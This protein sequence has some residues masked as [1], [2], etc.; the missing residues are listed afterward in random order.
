[1]DNPQQTLETE[2]KQQKAP[3]KRKWIIKIS[4][5]IAGIVGGYLY[6]YFV[7]CSTGT[8]PLKSNPWLMMLWGGLFAYL[9][10][11]IVLSTN[12]HFKK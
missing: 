11:D 5:T 3:S 6:Y 2:T 10:T 7:G 1:M 8:C 9:L 4:L 12:W